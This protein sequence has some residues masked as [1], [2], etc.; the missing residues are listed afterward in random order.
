MLNSREGI[1]I[2]Y[3]KKERNNKKLYGEDYYYHQFEKTFPH[4]I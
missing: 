3:L 1:N 2:P 4:I